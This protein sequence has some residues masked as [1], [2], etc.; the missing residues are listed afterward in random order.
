M[1]GIDDTGL[2]SKTLEEIL[3]EIAQ[4]QIDSI[5]DELDTSPPSPLGQANASTADQLAALW[6][7][8]Q[9]AVAAQ[10]P[11][12]ASGQALTDVCELTGTLRNRAIYSQVYANVTLAAGTYT[13]GSL[14]ATTT[15]D[16]TARFANAEE[17]VAPGGVLADQLFR[18]L[19]TGPV[20]ANAGTLTVIAESVSGWTAITNPLDAALGALI[21]SDTAL[22]VRRGTELARTGSATADAV[23]VDVADVADVTYCV[24]LENDTDDVDA[25]GQDPHSLQVVV[26]GGDDQDVADAIWASKAGGIG[27]FGADTMTVTDDQGYEHEV[28]FTRPTETDVYLDIELTCDADTYPGDSD[29]KEALAEWADANHT[30]GQDVVRSRAIAQ[31]FVLIPGLI[32]VTVFDIGLTN[33]TETAANLTIDPT[34]RAVFDTSRIDLVAALV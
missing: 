14:I 9:E 29:V 7:L 21:E 25:N 24:V 22:R 30:I 31:L 27:T 23:R 19:D 26:E 10:K 20:R 13:A 33:G 17:I 8:A 1:A 18:A 15:G 3:A 28:N 4:A 2:T 32:D 34:E 11:G 6:E 5:S 16:P 12:E